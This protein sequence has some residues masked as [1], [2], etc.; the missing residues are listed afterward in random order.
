MQLSQE[1]FRERVSK[2]PIKIPFNYSRKDQIILTM[3]CGPHLMA[4]VV[5]KHISNPDVGTFPGLT[6]NN[7]GLSYD[8]SFRTKHL[9]SGLWGSETIDELKSSNKN[10][11][12]QKIYNDSWVK[13]VNRYCNMEGVTLHN[14]NFYHDYTNGGYLQTTSIDIDR[15]MIDNE[16]IKRSIM[17]YN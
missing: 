15:N 9:M 17:S 4:R 11:N 14:F 1:M 16:T 5:R 8:P 2:H 6:F 7:H 13:E 12:L 3:A 10:I